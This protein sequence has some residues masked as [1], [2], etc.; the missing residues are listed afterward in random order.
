MTHSE[1]FA[2]SWF[3]NI[4]KKMIFVL[5]ASV[6]LLAAGCGKQAT[7]TTE[8]AAPTE[9]SN[10][11]AAESAA[12]DSDS[13]VSAEASQTNVGTSAAESSAEAESGETDAAAASELQE[14]SSASV[15]RDG[16]YVNLDDMHFFINGKKYTLGKTT[17]QEMIDDGVPFND[18]DIA[19]AGNN[20]NPSTESGGF[21]ITL[22]EYCSAQ[23]YVLNDTSENKKTSECY[24]SEIYLP[25]RQENGQK[26]L[27]FEFPTS[28][29]EEEIRANAGEPTEEK[30]YDGDN[31][32]VSRKIEYTKES[33]KY[34]G[35][36]GYTFEFANGELQYI[37]IDYMP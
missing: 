31:G 1:P 15:A 21:K 17:L 13:S 16:K 29:T 34:I 4:K 22:A 33:G 2:E 3:I 36:Y 30:Q 37:T 26:I 7:A 12:A 32:Y 6:M 35:D 24:I 8:N 28:A 25:T 20:L 9:P 11:E 18:N 27:S 10:Q 5:F 19:N 14:A 23:V